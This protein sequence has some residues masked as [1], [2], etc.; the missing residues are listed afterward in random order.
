M[1]PPSSGA[2]DEPTLTAVAGAILEAAAN[3]GICVLVFGN[4]AAEATER[5]YV[6]ESITEILGYGVEEFRTRSSKDL[7]NAENHRNLAAACSTSG[8]P[9]HLS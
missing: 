3:A 9:E 7:L 4:N 8:K 2:L 5:L 6:G 1:L